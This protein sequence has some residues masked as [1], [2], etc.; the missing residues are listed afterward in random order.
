MK[1][2][3]SRGRLSSPVSDSPKNLRALKKYV[4][5]LQALLLEANAIL[6]HLV[7][8]SSAEIVRGLCSRFHILQE[9]FAMR[10]QQARTFAIA[11]LGYV[12]AV[13]SFP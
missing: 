4:R 2:R 3:P 1:K 6:D 8:T 13:S 12:E 5:E 10:Y 7:L 9:Y 11:A